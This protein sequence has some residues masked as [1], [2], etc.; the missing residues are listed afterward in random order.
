MISREQEYED[1]DAPIPFPIILLCSN[2]MHN[3]TKM[4][5]FYPGI[6]ADVLYAFYGD[7]TDILNNY[8]SYIQKINFIIK[9]YRYEEKVLFMIFQKSDTFFK[10]STDKIIKTGSQLR[11]LNEIDLKKFFHDTRPSYGIVRCM[12]GGNDC[13][14]I[15]SIY[16]II[17]FFQ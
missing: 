15:I 2:A 9:Q 6:T 14:Y 8:V 4:R 7:Q 13:R 1:L 12:F 17:L 3:I 16:F 11:R 5:K 10:I